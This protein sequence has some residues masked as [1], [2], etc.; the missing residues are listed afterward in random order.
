MP[1]ALPVSASTPV[2]GRRI[3]VAGSDAESNSSS[4]DGL[5]SATLN[6]T[7]SSITGVNGD[8]NHANATLREPAMPPPIVRLPAL[9]E[10]QEEKE[11]NATRDLEM[12][13]NGNDK[14][15]KWLTEMDSQADPPTSKSSVMLTVSFTVVSV[16]MHILCFR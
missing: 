3:L 7:M 2:K 15:D 6:R 4:D 12:D 10:E 13:E 8:S 9:A 5:F 1:A 16:I 14:V 11:S